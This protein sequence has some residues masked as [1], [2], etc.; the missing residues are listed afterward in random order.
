MLENAVSIVAI[1]EL[2][3]SKGFVINCPYIINANRV[4]SCISLTDK[5]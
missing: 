1:E 5:K 4:H 2:S 3:F